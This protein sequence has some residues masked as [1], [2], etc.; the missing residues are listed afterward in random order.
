MHLVHWT[1]QAINVDSVVPAPVSGLLLT[2]LVGLC[3]RMASA[4]CGCIKW[5]GGFRFDG[6]VGLCFVL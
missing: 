2:L 5:Q 4:S 6:V 3:S 1:R